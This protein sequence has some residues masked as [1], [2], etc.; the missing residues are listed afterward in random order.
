MSDAARIRLWQLGLALAVLGLWEAG[1]TFGWFNAFWTS[2]PSRIATRLSEQLLS[3]E[4]LPHVALTVGEALAG[5]ATGVAIGMSLGLLLGVNRTLGA[6]FEPFIMAVNS[7]PRV[8]LGP[9]I[10]M[11][12]GIGP[13]AK[14]VLAFSLVVVVVMLNTYEGVRSI[15]PKLLHVMTILKASRW[16]VFQK[17]LLP[18]CVPWVFSAVRASIAFAIIGVLVGEFISARAGIGY[19]IDRASGAFDITGIFTPLVVLMAVA[20]LL[21]VALQRLGARALRWRTDIRL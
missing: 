1:A 20:V 3:G 12:F 10:V 2:S 14:I 19:L 17:C 16:Q 21:D 7:L 13:A 11:F 4:L 18:N 5:L 8:A 6:V 9:L 15:D